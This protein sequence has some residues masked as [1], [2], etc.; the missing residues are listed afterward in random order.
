M[1]SF[2]KKALLGVA[3]IVPIAMAPLALQAQDGRTYHDKAHHDDHQWN[4]QED[5]A[6]GVW[7]KDN[8]RKNHEFSTLSASSQQSYWNW[9]HQHSDAQLTREIK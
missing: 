8:H 3:L 9:R 2:W 4:G 1:T 7:V 6:Y 5:K